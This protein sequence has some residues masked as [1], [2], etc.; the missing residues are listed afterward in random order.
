MIP[1][2]VG[3]DP[4][5]SLN[6]SVLVHSLTRLASQPI[7]IIPINLESIDFYTETHTDGSTEF[8]YS[9]FLVPYM[10]EYNGWAI[11]M[12]CDMLART[13]VSELWSLCDS[14]YAIMCVQHNY[15]TSSTVKF[16][17]N[18]NRNYDRK[19]WS[20]VMLINCAHE[21]NRVLTPSLVAQQTG[22][23]LHQFKWL[24]DK[25]IGSLPAEW[26]W[27]AD[28]YGANSD[29]KLIHYTLGS[30]C[31]E[32]YRNV[33]MADHWLRELYDLQSTPTTVNKRSIS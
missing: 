24:D 20:S 4:R 2:F 6:F 9:R 23:Y 31:F 10:M 11:F 7:S 30:P 21:S 28:E 29:A 26:N 17:G 22:Q 12:D 32:E 3:Y 15:Q 14:R 27:L 8:S 18:V 1:I 13:D 33:P 25:L 19:N 5:E 16:L